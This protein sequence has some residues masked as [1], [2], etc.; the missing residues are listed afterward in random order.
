MIDQ[1]LCPIQVGVETNNRVEAAVH[2]TCRYLDVISSTRDHVVE[3]DFRN[4]F[5][6]SRRD[7]LLEAVA[8][9]CPEIYAFCM[10]A[11]TCQPTIKFNDHTIISATGMQQGDPLGA[12]LF[13]LALQPVLEQVTSELNIGYLDDV[14]HGGVVSDVDNDVDMIRREAGKLGLELNDARCEIIYTD[15]TDIDFNFYPSISRFVHITLLRL[16]LLC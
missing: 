11:Y 7:R 15:H 8:K 5:N 6:S 13:C 10:K 9:D 16:I 14:T 1:A 3:L 12:L 2:I 4:A